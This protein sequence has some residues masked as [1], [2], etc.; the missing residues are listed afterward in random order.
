MNNRAATRHARDSKIMTSLLK[1]CRYHTTTASPLRIRRAIAL[2]IA[3][4]HTAADVS[5]RGAA[6]KGPGFVQFARRLGHIARKEPGFPRR[7]NS[8]T[9]RRPSTASPASL[10]GAWRP[11]FEKSLA[12]PPHPC[13][14]TGEGEWPSEGGWRKG[15]P[16]PRKK[17][18]GEPASP[19]PPRFVAQAPRDHVSLG[20]QRLRLRAVALLQGQVHFQDVD[21]RYAGQPAQRRPGLLV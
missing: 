13:E 9:R 20:R 19:R 12:R 4:S 15:P 14:P 18:R 16:V 21:Q 2:S 5:Y 8:S 17:V 1:A 10:G 11:S 6:R 3:Q 7:G